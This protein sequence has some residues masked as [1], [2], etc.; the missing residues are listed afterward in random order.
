M[1]VRFESVTKQFQT[2]HGDVTAVD[3]LSLTI[4]TGKLIGFLG[5]SGCGK[6]TSLFMIA[7]IYPLTDGRILFDDIDVTALSPEKRGVGMVFQNYALY[8]HLTVRENIEFP[9]VNSKEMKNRLKQE[10]S[11]GG[12]QNV[13]RKMLKK[14]VSERVHEVAQLV[15][16]TEYLERKPGELSGGQQQR[17]AIARAIVKRPSILLLDEPLSNL[18]A[19]LRIQTREEIRSI[20]RRTGITTVFVTHDQEEALNICDEIAIMKNGMLQQYGAPQDVYDSPANRFVAEFL[21]GAKI[22]LFQAQIKD[23]VLFTGGLRVR[24]AIPLSDGTVTLGIRPENLISSAYTQGE[25]LKA[26]VERLIRLGGVTTV[27]AVLPGGESLRLMKENGSTLKPGDN[28][29]LNILPNA[30]CLFAEGG[31]KVWQG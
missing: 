25:G 12:K 28:I 2:K 1:Q 24:G 9:L 27:E 30:I 8:P 17:V 4:G 6:T 5:P 7:G 23:G 10:L 15:E 3:N 11:E 20:Q 18:D 29:G 13:T 16:I 21:G 26:R 14:T 31:E 19:R 22:N